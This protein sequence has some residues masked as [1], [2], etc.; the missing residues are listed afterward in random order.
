[1]I[2]LFKCRAVKGLEM[3]QRQRP[4][5][6]NRRKGLTLIPD[7]SAAARRANVRNRA[8]RKN[9]EEAKMAERA[10]GMVVMYWECPMDGTLSVLGARPM[11]EDDRQPGPILVQN[12]NPM[13][14]CGHCNTMHARYPEMIDFINRVLAYH[15]FCSH[16]SEV[17][18]PDEN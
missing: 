18:V 7:L 12:P 3:N 9:Y 14:V 5:K 8:I 1:M 2:L 6:N 4:D 13:E 10:P 17:G 11:G 15:K 16:N